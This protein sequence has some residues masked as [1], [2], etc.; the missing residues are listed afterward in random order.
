M[1]K[2]REK[3]YPLLMLQE[4][5]MLQEMML[6]QEITR[7]KELREIDSFSSHPHIY[8]TVTGDDVF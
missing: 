4:I 6:L 1:T 5:M 8:C 7:I 2:M 3:L